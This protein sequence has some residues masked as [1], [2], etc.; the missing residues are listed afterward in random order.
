MKLYKFALIFF[1][2]ILL[3][4]RPET[5][6]GQEVYHSESLRIEQLTTHTFVHISQLVIPNYGSFPCNGMIYVNEGE[7][8]VFDTPIGDTISNELINW[9]QKEKNLEV[10]GIVVNHFHDDCLGGIAA[11]HRACIP[12][13]A[14]EQTIALAKDGAF[15]LPQHSFSEK[16]EMRAGSGTVINRYFGAGHT[17]DNIVSYV[18]G[19]EVLFGGCMIKEMGA[20]R[21]NLNDAD[22]IAWPVT[23]ALV[24]KAY[25]RLKHVIPG[26]GKVG[27]TELLD[28]TI[29]MFK[30]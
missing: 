9:L 24:K 30:K 17:A 13:Y 27:G 18:P 19:E 16:L 26:H 8:I 4:M 22:T 11:F 28:Y 3:S 2:F 20:G 12:S 6:L 7:A 23:V 29:K 21:G 25:P 5:S 10:K 15:E 14:S 1:L